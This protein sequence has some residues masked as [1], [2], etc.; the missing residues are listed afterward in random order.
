MLNI[1]KPP[2]KQR[3]NYSKKYYN[4][5]QLKELRCYFITIKKLTP[6]KKTN[7]IFSLHDCYISQMR[8]TSH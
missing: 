1:F 2:F 4:H 7:T 8:A 5:Q 6:F 3:R